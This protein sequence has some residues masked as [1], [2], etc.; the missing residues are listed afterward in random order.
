MNSVQ[1]KLLNK[2]GE[3]FTIAAITFIK[4]GLNH[5]YNALSPSTA[6]SVSKIYNIISNLENIRDIEL[7]LKIAVSDMLSTVAPSYLKNMSKKD[8]ENIGNQ[9]TPLWPPVKTGTQL[10]GFDGGIAALAIAYCRNSD[11]VKDVAGILKQDSSELIRKAA[12]AQLLVTPGVPGMTKLAIKKY[13]I[14]KQG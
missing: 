10:K 9:L 2:G 8:V 3:V 5:S 13:F 6:H 1:K 4:Y 7:P 11:T 14:N 12:L